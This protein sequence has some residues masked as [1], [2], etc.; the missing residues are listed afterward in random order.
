MELSYRPRR[1]R[2]TPALRAMVRENQLAPADFIYP[3]FVHEGVTNEPIGAM[4]GCQRWSLEG[5][6]QEVGRA[7]ALGI[8]CV[9]LF[10]KVADG[11]KT[12]DG[13]ECF[14][15]GG[16]IPRAIRRLKEV[17]PEMAI[18]TDVALDPYSCDGHDGIVS[19]EGVVLNDETVALLCKQAI[20]Q[21]RA[22][23]DLIGPSDM[24]DGRVGSIREALDEE[25]FEHVGI[26]SYTAKYASAYYGPFREALDS[27]PRALAS[28]PIPKD[29]STYQM[30]PANGREAITE[31][32]LDE[33]EGAD[34]MMVKPGLA[35]LDI[36]YRLRAESELP[37][38]AYNVSGEYAMVKAAAEK[39]WIDERAVVLETLLC[40]KRAGA[41]LILTYHAGDADQ[42]L[43]E[44]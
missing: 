6:V 18:M 1:L 12:E 14:N 36:I 34:I 43:G 25:G 31:A 8:R 27:A 28:K 3:L 41:D 44:G 4:P 15:E 37:I 16:L 23:A 26:I 32:Q 5:L 17:H 7:W 39:G 35:Y 21:A 22:G 30:D 10:P 42:W 24:M 19:E 13:A 20:A 2:R 29:K 40:F 11:L 9:V 38:A 33:T